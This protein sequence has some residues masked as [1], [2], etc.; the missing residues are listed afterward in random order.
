MKFR[1]SPA[2]PVR[3]EKAMPFQQHFL[4]RKALKEI[5]QEGMPCESCKVY[6][7]E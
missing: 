4:L 6:L 1:K 7:S 5:Q 3:L 2:L